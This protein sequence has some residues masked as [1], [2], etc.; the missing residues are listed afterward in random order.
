[1]PSYPVVLMQ[2]L[3][4]APPA[5]SHRGLGGHLEMAIELN[6]A[7]TIAAATNACAVAR[8]RARARVAEHWLPPLSVRRDRARC[9]LSAPLPTTWQ[10]GTEPECLAASAMERQ[11]AAAAI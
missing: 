11:L 6:W 10:P 9:A 8:F 1:M 3:P 4:R 5:V 7:Q 2:P